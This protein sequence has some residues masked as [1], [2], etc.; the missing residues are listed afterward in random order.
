MRTLKFFALLVAAISLIV[1]A[2]APAAPPPTSS[3]TKAPAAAPTT[4]PQAAP[5]AQAKAAAP[6]SLPATP[7]PAPINVK[8][9][10][11]QASLSDAP[12]I[13][14]LERG[15]FAEQ[16]LNVDAVMHQS[17][18]AILSTLGTGEMDVAGGGWSVAR[19]PPAKQRI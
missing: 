11:V 7:K 15:Y 1:S 5:T 8:L 2:C 14:A 6:T 9:S 4:A 16:S 19:P 12:L 10:R 18:A 17:S 3:P 13:I